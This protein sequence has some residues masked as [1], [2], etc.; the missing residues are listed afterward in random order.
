MRRYN[1]FEQHSNGYSTVGTKTGFGV[2]KEIIPPFYDDV[3]ILEGGF[4]S[5]RNNNV[6]STY[7]FEG[8]KV[9]DI[10]VEAH[11]VLQE[12]PHKVFKGIYIVKSE[13][14]FGVIR[15]IV[16]P[17]YD[18]IRFRRD[19]IIVKKNFREGVFNIQGKSLI[20]PTYDEISAY[21]DNDILI[22][23][24]TDESEEIIC[25]TNN[26]TKVLRLPYNEIT[27]CPNGFYVVRKG[28]KYGALNS[29][30]KEVIPAIYTHLEYYKD[31][32]F[33][34]SDMALTYLVDEHCNV[35]NP[36][37]YDLVYGISNIYVAKR[38]NLYGLLDKDLN[39]I[40]TPAYARIIK[41]T[42]N[43]L[44]L[45]ADDNLYGFVFLQNGMIKTHVAPKYTN[46]SFL[47]DKGYDA[48]SLLKVRQ[49]KH[50]ALCT[51]DHELLTPFK[52][53]N[54][55]MKG[56]DIFVSLPKGNSL[57]ARFTGLIDGNGN[58]LIKPLYDNIYRCG[59]GFKVKKDTKW[60][61]FDSHYNQI[62]AFVYDD[63]HYVS[64]Y[65]LSG[66][67]IAEVVFKGKTGKYYW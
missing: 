16:R 49:G 44:Q 7:D 18:N 60:A 28:Y 23:T 56:E 42:D 46:V 19:I 31:N 59:Q 38:K 32:L 14:G 13:N 39:E 45:Q 10:S 27:P 30:F 29:K 51:F 36:L 34:A 50:Y 21:P 54:I 41:L 37:D 20:K 26:Y 58:E 3:K 8:N 53:S 33:I 65:N 5:V 55:F 12:K 17:I 57:I 15:Q 52:Y 4:I 25:L 62:T 35:K 66:E 40:L 24:N 67:K 63:I 47:N 11:K 2:I 1:F 9:C 6:V 22:C 48:P 64:E 61:I 43:I